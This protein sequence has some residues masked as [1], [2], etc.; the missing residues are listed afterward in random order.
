MPDECLVVNG[1]IKVSGHIIQPSDERVKLN[2]CEL[3]TEDQLENINQIRVVQ[4]KY[5]PT[6][7]GHS[8]LDSHRYQTGIIA[9][10]LQKILPDAVHNGGNV[11][12]SDGTNIDNFLQV[13]KV[14][15][16]Y[17]LLVRMTHKTE[18]I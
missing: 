12:L 18:Q 11:K 3:N 2:I 5:D 1:N 8:E 6:F 13:N 15:F 17:V 9:Q 16:Y 4:Y 7:A 10:E 14:G